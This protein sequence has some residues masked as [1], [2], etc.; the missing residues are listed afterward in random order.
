VTLVAKIGAIWGRWLVQ[1]RLGLEGEAE[2]VEVWATLEAEDRATVI[3]R[4]AAA[5]ADAAV[6]TSA[7]GEEESNEDIE[8]GDSAGDVTRIT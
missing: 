1:L 3:E 4:L 7:V 2:L 6:A 5:M 8:S